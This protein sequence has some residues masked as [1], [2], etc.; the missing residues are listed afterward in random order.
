MSFDGYVREIGGLPRQTTHLKFTK[1]KEICYGNPN[2]RNDTCSPPL[3][4]RH[5]RRS[6]RRPAPAHRPDPLAQEA[7]PP[8]SFAGL[9]AGTDAETR[10]LLVHQL[11][12]PH[13]P[14]Q[15]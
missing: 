12:L 7:D 1:T 4:R 11:H 6:D 13:T 15:S 3:P 10:A 5:S 8:R 14:P 2:P 9:A